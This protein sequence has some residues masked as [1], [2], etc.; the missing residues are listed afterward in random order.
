MKMRTVGIILS[1]VLIVFL[2]VLGFLYYHEKN[3]RVEFYATVM[4]TNSKYSVVA[5]L[6]SDNL[7]KKY[8]LIKI[9]IRNLELGSVVKLD[10]LKSFK[11]TNP[12]EATVKDYQ[13]IIAS[14]TT[15]MTTSTEKQVI[16]TT[17]TAKVITTTKVVT[18]TT[19]NTD[20]SVINTITDYQNEVSAN[21]GKTSFKDNA[22][23]MFT[24][25]I[26]FIFYD[27]TI[28]GVHFSDLP[29]KGKLLVIKTA[30]SLDN[31]INEY[32]PNYKS[33]LSS[34]YQNAKNK[35]VALY[36]TKTSEY[37]DNHDDV[38]EQAKSEFQDMKKSFGLTWD[39]IKS[40]ASGGVSKL[41][42][43]YEIYSGK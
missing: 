40:L 10:C 32:Y 12:P 21:K 16:G 41:K 3:Q 7:S 34:S 9:P 14:S 15:A 42:E 4:E 43:W 27:G 1:T 13:V 38:C 8:S 18:T 35:L 5:P 20:E 6:K 22:K 11:D 2:A 39:I 23:K 25:V 26:Y 33:E 29:N 31:K 36:L 24:T 37:C 28:N 17:T 30:L 19:I